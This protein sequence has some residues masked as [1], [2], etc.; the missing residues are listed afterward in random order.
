MNTQSEQCTLH[1]LHKLCTLHNLHKL[2][3]QN[4]LCRYEQPWLTVKLDLYEQHFIHTLSFKREKLIFFDT[5]LDLLRV[6]VL[7]CGKYY[8]YT[9]LLL[10]YENW[11]Y[12]IKCKLHD[13]TRN[14]VTCN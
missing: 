12:L 7:F 3:M 14:I 2:C 6:F 4:V 11:K 9:V 8:R 1:N 10:S 5:G 13:K